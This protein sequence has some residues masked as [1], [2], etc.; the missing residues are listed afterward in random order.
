M[1]A[2]QFRKRITRVFDEEALGR[3][4]QGFA[5]LRLNKYEAG[6]ARNLV[7]S[8]DDLI[9][10][11]RAMDDLRGTFR[12]H[13]H[14]RNPAPTDAQRR[15]LYN[16]TK[17]YFDHVYSCLGQVLSLVARFS[18]VF[19]QVNYSDIAPF[20]RWLERNE[21]LRHDA[22]EELE[23]ARLYRAVLNHPQQFPVVNWHTRIEV[24][25]RELAFV[26]LYGAESRSGKI[27]PGATR[28]DPIL[29]SGV[30]E[31]DWTLDPPDDLSVLNIVAN[32]AGTALAHIVIARGSGSAF[33]S[34]ESRRD[35]VFRSI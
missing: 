34:A 14:Y 5:G 8:L 17:T 12:R 1:P 27:P 19:G 22:I 6:A 11:Q 21:W 4:K 26:V 3:L 32:V 10:H 30:V 13:G 20:I 16:L 18:K 2:G 33:Q 24:G 9:L 7:E 31:G 35:A 15:Q 25:Y 28:D 23:R 29:A